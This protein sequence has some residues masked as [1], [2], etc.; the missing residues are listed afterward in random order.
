LTDAD[1]E[2]VHEGLAWALAEQDRIVAMTG[3]AWNEYRAKAA[4]IHARILA[5]DLVVLPRTCLPEELKGRF[6]G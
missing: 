4:G 3:D 5:Q 1:K 2:E 6:G